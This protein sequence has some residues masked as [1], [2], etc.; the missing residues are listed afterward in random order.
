[1]IKNSVFL[2][3]PVAVFLSIHLD[4]SKL[5]VVVPLTTLVPFAFTLKVARAVP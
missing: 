2:N 4:T 5:T 3:S 1:M